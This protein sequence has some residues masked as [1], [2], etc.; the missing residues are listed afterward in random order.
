[1]GNRNLAVRNL[2]IARLASELA[3]GFDQEEY[4]EST[5]MIVGEATT[6]GHAGK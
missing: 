1:M 4:A 6:R 3:D 2:S 5:R